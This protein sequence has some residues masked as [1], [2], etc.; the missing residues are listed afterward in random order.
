MI[1]AFG[2]LFYQVLLTCRNNAY[3]YSRELATNNRDICMH[4]Y[5][6]SDTLTLAKR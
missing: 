4:N 2:L 3:E 6:M 5:R 1:E